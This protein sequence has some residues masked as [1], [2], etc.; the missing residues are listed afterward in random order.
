MRIT[1]LALAA[2][3]CAVLLAQP[4][5]VAGGGGAEQPPRCNLPRVAAA[6]ISPAAFRE[7]YEDAGRPVVLTGA[8]AHWPAIG[9]EW[10]LP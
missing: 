4:P 5:T 6:E 8:A 7:Q 10:A 1:A 2:A 9:R 3:A